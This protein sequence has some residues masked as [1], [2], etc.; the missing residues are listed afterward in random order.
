MLGGLLRSR[1][2]L[3]HTPLPFPFVSTSIRAGPP[4]YP[5]FLATTRFFLVRVDAPQGQELGLSHSVEPGW[6]TIQQG[7]E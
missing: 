3:I 1:G 6:R 7:T 2:P 4:S 5:T